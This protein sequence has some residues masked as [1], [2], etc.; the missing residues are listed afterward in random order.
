[1]A[2]SVHFRNLLLTLLLGFLFFATHVKS[3]PDPR[4]ADVEKRND[5][6]TALPVPE[7]GLAIR[8]A[9]D[10]KSLTK[11]VDQAAIWRSLKPDTLAST[12]HTKV[13]NLPVDDVRHYGSTFCYG[14]VVVVVASGQRLV[15]AHLA[16]VT[17]S[18]M[19]FENNEAFL[20]NIELP[21]EHTLYANKAT[22]DPAPRVMVFGPSPSE[23]G[24]FSNRG[25]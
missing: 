7:P 1:M 2:P 13:W 11:R 10:K 25:K 17:G 14:C 9:E 23:N 16:E 20:D 3:Y 22:L 21:L 5:D 12:G 8:D 24:D 18:K 15:I 6:R 19:N 4:V